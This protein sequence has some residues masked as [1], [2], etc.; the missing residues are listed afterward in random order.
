VADAPDDAGSAELP[1]LGAIARRALPNLF[2]ATIVPATLFYV[3]LVHV[4]AGAAMVITLA[5]ASGALVRRLTTGQRVPA[6]LLLSMLGLVVRTAVGLGS[7]NP[8]L[9]FVQPAL[10]A[11]AMGFVFLGSV[12]FGRPLVASLASDFYPLSADVAGRPGVVRLFRRLTLLWAAVH[13]ATAAATLALLASLPLATFVA[14]KTMACLAITG[15]GVALTVSWSL[16]TARHEGLAP[17][18]ARGARLAG[19]GPAPALAA[20]PA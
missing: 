10:S 8:A 5:W 16:R 6:I 17:A 1:A 12:A 2:E 13:V 4:G 15:G 7:G 19:A 18:R 14:V 20:F 11:A 3:V 9:Y